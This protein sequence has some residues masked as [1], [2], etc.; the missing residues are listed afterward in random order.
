MSGDEGDVVCVGIVQSGQVV[1]WVHGGREP[2]PV[3]WISEGVFAEILRASGEVGVPFL[4]TLDIYAQTRISAADCVNILARWSA[5][6]DALK[7]TPSEAPTAAMRRLMELCADG[8][9]DMEL[10]IEGP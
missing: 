9:E 5:V 6:E 3:E 1:D 7:G 8:R 10:L 2:H 4:P